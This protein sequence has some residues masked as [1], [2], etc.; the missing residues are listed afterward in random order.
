MIYVVLRFLSFLVL[1]VFFGL[2]VTGAENIPKKGG[3]ILACNH[4][5]YFDPVTFGVACPRIKLNYM[6]KEELFD[7]P[8]LGWL[9][10]RLHV[11]PIKRNSADLGAI[12]ES[13]RRVKKGEGL[14]LFPEGRRTRNGQPG[15]AL[16]G[17]GFLASK[18][19][20]VV[21]PA[22]IEGSDKVL[23]VHAKRIVFAR[24]HVRF[25]KQIIVERRLP[26]QDAARDIMGHIRQL[27]CQAAC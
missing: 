25:G 11:F 22:F 23:P 12:K 26:Y 27:S 7:K 4:A 1:R 9:I 14:L 24:I 13:I 8:V 21:I 10:P 19:G 2:R 15:E 3:F 17:V 5:S 20:V 6:A 16:P 18:L